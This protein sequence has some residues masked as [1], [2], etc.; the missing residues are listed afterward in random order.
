MRTALAYTP[1]RGRLQGAAIPAAVAYLLAFVVLAFTYWSPIVLIAIAG[2]VVVAG[3]A[4]GA[5]TALLASLRWGLGL[6]VVIVA[7][8]GL[9][10]H[11]GETVLVRGFE[12][13]GLGALDVTL[14][15]LAEGAVLAFRILV[16]LM[17]FAVYSACVDPDR[18]L[19]LL[20]PVARRSA[21]TATLIARLVP[22]AA[23]DHV[24]L[25][26]A[27]T[28]RGP[29]AA[30]AG[31]AALVRRLVAGSLDRAVDAGATLELRGYGQRASRAGVGS[32]RRSRH[33]A[34]FAAA[35]LGIAAG[36]MG[37]RLL[38]LGGFDA[39]PSLAID[40]DVAT[41]ALAAAIPAFAWAP[42]AGERSTRRA[43]ARRR[44]ARAGGVG[45]RA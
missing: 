11:R 35:G 13:P 37:A 4:A 2:G 3:L 18:V 17:A 42:F 43:R 20:R 31:R 15:A 22:L 23:A 40:V 6:A 29:A 38:G 16:V 39:Y 10:T 30:P 12:V 24:R 32:I 45:A 36:G 44:P 7:V 21:L 33:D 5:R 41:L 34:R 14:E 9:V 1:R 19:R 8:N 26:E 27:A 25:R 28:L